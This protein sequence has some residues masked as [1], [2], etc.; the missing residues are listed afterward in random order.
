ME[1]QPSESFRY[2][3]DQ[4]RMQGHGLLVMAGNAKP[5][6]SSGFE[7]QPVDADANS[8]LKEDLGVAIEPGLV[9]DQ[10]A[11]RVTVN[12]QQGGFMFRSMVEYP[13][14]PNVTN[15]NSE[16]L[17][18]AGLE[19]VSIPFASPLIWTGADDA[20]VELMRSS[21][22]ASV[23]SGP[24]FDVSPLM[25]RAERF[26]GMSMRSSLLALAVGGAV[27]SAFK[28]PPESVAGDS[29][30]HITHADA[31]RMIVVG[32]PALLDDEFID[33]GNLVALLNMFDWLSGDAG[34]I[35]L[36]SR[37]VTQRPLESLSSAGRSFFKGVWMFALPILIG[38]I[39][40]WRW[41]SLKKRRAIS[42]V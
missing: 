7:V 25:N 34:L 37:G 30:S 33:G 11:T 27:E 40:L 22:R 8:W 12:Q 38:L 9:I 24:P 41:L 1:K 35:E 18:T 26:S 42:A 6:L 16:H 23:Q 5:M 39:G 31:S 14:L 36:R 13:F 4:F 32:S 19:S 21:A 10:Q 3:L 2:H 20:S 29:A 28:Q 15:L 17:V